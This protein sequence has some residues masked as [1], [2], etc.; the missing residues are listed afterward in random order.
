M[1]A[2]E[3]DIY[4]VVIVG[5]GMVGISLALMLSAQHQPWKILLV[6]AQAYQFSGAPAFRPSFDARST[7]LSWGARKIFDN[8]NL[9]QQLAEHACAIEQVHVSDRG[10][11]GLSRMQAADA[12]VD[13][14]GYV[15]ENRR[16]GQVL[17]QA[18]STVSVEVRAPA[19]ISTARMLRDAAQLTLD[20]GD[21]VQG[22]LLV[23]ADGA[24]SNTAELLGIHS[25]SQSYGQTAIIAN[26]A[27][28]EPHRGVAYERFTDWGPMAMLPLEPV[29][30]QNRSALVWTLPPD[31]AVEL[32]GC[33]ESE[34][35]LTLQER[36]GHRLG[37][38]T[39]VGQRFAYPLALTEAA[40]QVRRNL[41]VLGNAAH[42]LHPVAGQ[43]FNL[44]LRDAACLAE[45]LGQARARNLPFNS[46]EILERYQ[47]QQ[48]SDQRNTVLFSDSLPKLFGVNAK[49]VQL[50]RNGGLV[51]MDLLAPLRTRFA[52]FG[53]GMAGR[54]ARHG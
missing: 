46:L 17:L 7:A 52:R 13:A 34:F 39:A 29:D 51:A 41:V 42:S 40:E 43:G 5:G 10:H 16:L 27:L 49:A 23:I 4:D 12:G 15:V 30:G 45:V 20:S 33:D 11:V 9:W 32:M 2:P 26:I 38:L 48:S 44:S 53:M 8:L 36:F 35:L 31:K 37:N 24:A 19:Q 47:Q 3:S 25:H 6:E 50:A 28:G 22:K 14:L 1:Q 18:L 21:K 54:E